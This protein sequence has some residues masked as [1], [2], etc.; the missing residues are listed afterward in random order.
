MALYHGDHATL[1]DLW[2]WFSLAAALCQAVRTAAQKRLNERLSTLA[3]TYARAALGLP[4]LA[5]YLL[6]VLL[7]VDPRVPDFSPAFLFAASCGAAVQVASTSLLIELF[8]KRGFAVASM[9]VKVDIVLIALIG[10]VFFS[11]HITP[12]GFAAL[13][14]VLIGVVLLSAGRDGLASLRDQ[15]SVGRAALS[16]SG[17]WLALTCALFYALSFLFMREATLTVGEGSFLWRGA[18]AV[19]VT[20]TMQAVLLGLWLIWREPGFLRSFWNNRGGVAIVG[21]T[22]AAGSMAWFSAFALQNAS[23]VRA[24]AQVEVIFTLL[25][26][27]LYFKERLTRLEVIGT[28]IT[29]AGV[30]LFRLAD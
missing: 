2:I 22:S 25:I 29:L 24:V 8:R 15:F 10:S 19:I 28:I 9:L 5:V 18:W 6:A 1:D 3:T 30:L 16:A 7:W 14:I 27:A 21:A 23:Y 11:E 26:S 12:L 20:V 17:L 13:L 4:V